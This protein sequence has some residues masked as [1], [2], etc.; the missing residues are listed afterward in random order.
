V[1]GESERVCVVD[2][3]AKQNELDERDRERDCEAG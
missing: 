2:E 1:L 3:K